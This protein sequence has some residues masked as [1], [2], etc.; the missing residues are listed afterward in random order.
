[1]TGAET[2]D[3][4]EEGDLDMY[5][6]ISNGSGHD[7]RNNLCCKPRVAQPQRDAARRIA[8]PVERLA[9]VP[10]AAWADWCTPCIRGWTICHAAGLIAPEPPMCYGIYRNWYRC[11]C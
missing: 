9:G 3:P 2:G 1:M 5:V 7:D 8:A 10:G 11:R 6:R 4:Q